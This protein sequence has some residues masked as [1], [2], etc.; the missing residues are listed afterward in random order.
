MGQPSPTR[1]EEL[2]FRLAQAGFTGET[3]MAAVRPIRRDPG[4]SA[5]AA[6]NRRV[7]DLE[8]LIAELTTFNDLVAGGMEFPDPDAVLT[9]ADT[10]VTDLSQGFEAL[11]QTSVDLAA[12]YFP[13]A[14]GVGDIQRSLNPDEAVVMIVPATP[15]TLIFAVT[16]DAFQMRTAGAEAVTL[17][18][19]ADRLRTA[20]GRPLGRGAMALDG[21]ARPPQPDVLRAEAARIYDGLLRPVEAV[22]QGKPRLFV[23]ATAQVGLGFPF[24]MLLTEPALPGQADAELAWLVRRHAVTVVPTLELIRMRDTATAPVPEATYYLGFG[25]PDYRFPSQLGRTN[26]ATRLLSDLAPLPDAAEEVRA[27][28]AAFGP[29]NGLAVTGVD[30]TENLLLEVSRS[31]TLR[32]FTVLHFATHGLVFGDHEA[33]TDP[34]LALTPMIDLIDLTPRLVGTFNAPTADGILEAHE[35]RQLDLAARLVILSACSSGNAGMDE[36][37]LTSLGAAFLA[38]GADRVRPAWPRATPGWPTP[39][40]RCATHLCRSST[41]VA[42]GRTRRGGR[43]SRWSGSPERPQPDRV[44]FQGNL[45]AGG[46]LT[47]RKRKAG[48]WR[49]DQQKTCG[50]S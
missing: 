46:A 24:E 15:E 28:A 10:A 19:A 33:V 14:L 44:R 9:S 38:A 42:D 1:S 50:I 26:R 20:I 47:L 25:G 2:A 45:R 16:R 17:W 39:R 18:E 36:D 34:L 43:H 11:M 12:V 5:N 7:H 29:D 49:S 32:Q 48:P 31:G 13:S 22:L 6:L 23:V 3:A 37:G 8:A 40:W 35:V 4:V 21:D 27:V 30:A 41:A